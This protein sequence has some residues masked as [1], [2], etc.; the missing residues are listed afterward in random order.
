M[1][2]ALIFV[3]VGASAA[4]AVTFNIIVGANGNLAYYPPFVQA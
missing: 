4:H 1:L 2:A 3:F